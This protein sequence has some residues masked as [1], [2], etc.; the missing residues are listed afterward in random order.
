MRQRQII[1]TE[2]ANDFAEARKAK[3]W[4]LDQTC[5]QLEKIGCK[6]PRSAYYRIE[7]GKG[8]LRLDYAIKIAEL[9]NISLMHLIYGGGTVNDDR[10]IWDSGFRQLG[11]EAEDINNKYFLHRYGIAL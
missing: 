1:E 9:F 3:G 11:A 10:T 8:A 4:T 5:E 6:I 7:T 2:L